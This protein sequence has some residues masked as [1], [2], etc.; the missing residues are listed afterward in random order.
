VLQAIFMHKMKCCQGESSKKNL[1]L[2][3][4]E[5]F[6]GMNVY[7]RFNTAFQVIISASLQYRSPWEERGNNLSRP[8]PDTGL[9]EVAV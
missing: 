3:S 2:A 5:F 6:C 8:H 7:L 1:C 4:Q 9:P